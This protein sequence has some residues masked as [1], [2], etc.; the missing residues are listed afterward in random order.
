MLTRLPLDRIASDGYSFLVETLFMASRMRARIAEVPI[1]FVERRLGQSKLS[2]AV[3]FESVLMPWKLAGRK[4]M[5][6]GFSVEAAPAA[7]P[8]KAET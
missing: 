5:P 4:N 6:A 7:A 8:G 3:I 2:R 1:T